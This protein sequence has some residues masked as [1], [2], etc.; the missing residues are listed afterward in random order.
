M[1]ELKKFTGFKP[2]KRYL[3]CSVEIL[4]EF[5]ILWM[6]RFYERRVGGQAKLVE[7]V[8]SLY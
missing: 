3:E 2:H 1:I 4:D 7:I 6:N 8:I 5:V